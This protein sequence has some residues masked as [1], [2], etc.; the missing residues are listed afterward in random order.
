MS[1]TIST[2]LSDGFFIFIACSCILLLDLTIIS[3]SIFSSGRI[4][5]GI[6]A[7]ILGVKGGVR[8]IF[9][10]GTVIIGVFLFFMV[11]V[12]IKTRILFFEVISLGDLSLHSASASSSAIAS[13]ALLNLGFFS[14]STHYFVTVL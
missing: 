10:A 7:V 12:I 1:V 13:T 4:G 3:I 8:N 5:A 2:C 9:G 6:P 11:L 14:F